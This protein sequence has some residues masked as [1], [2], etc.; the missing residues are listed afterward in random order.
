VILQQDHLLKNV[1]ATE[2]CECCETREK[3]KNKKLAYPSIISRKCTRRSFFKKKQ[4]EH[5]LEGSSPL[6]TIPNFDPVNPVF[7]D[8]MH[9]LY[10]GITKWLLQN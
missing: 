2:V 1:K 5:H 4:N 10:F 3:A 6:L 9:L 7:L 8:S